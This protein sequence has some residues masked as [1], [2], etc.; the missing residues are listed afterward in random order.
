MSPRNL[1]DRLCGRFKGASDSL[2]P[3]TVARDG[4]GELPAVRLQPA[5]NPGDG[6]PRAG[7]PA[8]LTVQQLEELDAQQ[9]KAPPD[10]DTWAEAPATDTLTKAYWKDPDRD[11]QGMLSSDRIR[12]YH[13]RVGRM[14]RPFDMQNLKPASYELTL[15]PKCLVEGNPVTLGPEQRILTIAPNSIVYVSM[16]EQILMP[17]WLVGRFDLIIDLIYEGL[18]LGTGPQV[19]P[20]FQGVLSCPLHNISSREIEIEFCK[21]LVKIDFVKTSFG[22]GARLPAVM[23][24]AELRAGGDLEHGYH[25]Q[26]LR[27][28]SSSKNWRPPITFAKNV[29]EVKSSVR[30][31]DDRTKHALQLV[32]DNRRFSV[33]AAVATV[34]LLATLFA[35]AVGGFVYT[36][37]YTDGRVSDARTGSKEE[38]EALRKEI[39]ILNTWANSLGARQAALCSALPRSR[40]A[41]AQC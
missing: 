24:D 23:S 20:G 40:R 11:W 17:H 36:L 19:D 27:L 32:R 5:D 35:G 33:G 14:I 39:K 25:D 4:R 41:A 38:V 13:Y 8:V 37:S 21:P 30:A 29:R 16:R 2:A 22:R 15:G 18:L 3:G 34:A 28:W 1:L 31:L 12:D 7:P 26:V 10:V 6:V 9:L